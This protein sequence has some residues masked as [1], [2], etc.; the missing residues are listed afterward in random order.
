VPDAIAH[1][2]SFSLAEYLGHC[3]GHGYRDGQ[4][5][6]SPEADSNGIAKGDRHRQADGLADRNIR[7]LGRTHPNRNL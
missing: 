4:G 7:R 1:R 3:E 5:L 6:R 2:H